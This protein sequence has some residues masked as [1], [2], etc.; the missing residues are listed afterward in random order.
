METLAESVDDPERQ[1]YLTQKQSAG[2]RGQRSAFEI[3]HDFP[4][5]E[6]LKVEL[7]CITLFMHLLALLLILIVSRQSN[8][9]RQKGLF[10]PYA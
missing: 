9:T 10:A 5:S 7:V 3:S 2:V 8:Y 6:P 1:I 4:R